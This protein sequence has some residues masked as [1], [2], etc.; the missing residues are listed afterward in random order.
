[1]VPAIYQGKVSPTSSHLFRFIL[2]LGQYPPPTA[3]GHPHSESKAKIPPPTVFLLHPSQPLSH[4]S[5]LIIASL[6]PNTPNISFRC[7]TPRGNYLQWAD[8]TDVGDFIKDAARATEFEICIS[9]SSKGAERAET[10][11]HV[12]VPS[13]EDR[14]RFMKRRLEIIERQLRQM[15]ELKQTCDGE[16]H[17]GARRMAMGGFGM[18]VVYWGTVA[19]L[20][21]WDYGW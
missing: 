16:A 6:A 15:E 11:I 2:P 21:F 19:R 7:S 8:S 13:F 3:G 1:M 5:R 12:D 4:V 14:T 17:Q 10:I 18:L 20:T 9:D